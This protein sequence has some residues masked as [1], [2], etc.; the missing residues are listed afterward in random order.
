MFYEVRIPWFILFL[1]TCADL[2]AQKIRLYIGGG[3]LRRCCVLLYINAYT[4]VE[5]MSIH[6]GKLASY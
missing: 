6:A 2:P 5:E 1:I 3:A 4:K